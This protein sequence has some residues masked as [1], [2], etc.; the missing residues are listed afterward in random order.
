M[1][2]SVDMALNR[3][4]ECCHYRPK[5]YPGWVVSLRL[6]ESA[7][8]MRSVAKQVTMKLSAFVDLKEGKSAGG[9][10]GCDSKEYIVIM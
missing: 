8:C 3:V 2:V 6:T 4:D 5:S 9:K 1:A 10:I 7:N